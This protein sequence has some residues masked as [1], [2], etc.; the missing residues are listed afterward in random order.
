MNVLKVS[1]TVLTPATTVSD[2]ILV[3]A[4]LAITLVVIITL[5]MV[6]KLLGN[7]LITSIH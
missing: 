5:V 1:V 6:I 2:H 4:T 7:T 3:A